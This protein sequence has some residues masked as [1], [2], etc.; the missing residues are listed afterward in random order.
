MQNLEPGRGAQGAVLDMR[1]LREHVA[2]VYAGH[3]TAVLAHLCFAI[4]IAFFVYFHQGRTEP[5]WWLIPI[6]AADLGAFF[7]ARWTPAVPLEDTPRWALR[8]TVASTLVSGATAPAAFFFVASA[9][10]AE[11]TVVTVVIIGS[12]TRAVQARWPLK[13]AIFGYGLPMKCGLIAGLIWNGGAISWFLAAFCTANLILTLRAGV[14]QNRRLTESLMLRFENETLA[15]RLREQVAATERASAEKT[16]FL[17]AA[18]HDL[19]QPMHAIALFGAAMQHGLHQHPERAN[20][21][22]L[23][24]AVDALGASLDTMLDVS[25]LD[26]GVISAMPRPFALDTLLLA[27]H[28]TF[29]AQAEQKGL[30]LRVRASGLWVRSDPQLLLRM[31]SNL[32]DNALK[33]TSQGG[34]TVC[35]LTRGAQVWLEVRDT[36]IGIAPDQLGRIFEEFY[37]VNNPGRD[38]ARGL[39]IGLAIVHRLARL[40][41]HPVQVRSHVGRGTRFRLVLPAAEAQAQQSHEEQ[42]PDAPDGAV[43]HGFAAPRLHGRVL[44]IDDEDEIREGMVQLLR[45]YGLDAVAVPDE[46]AAEQVLADRDALTRPFVLLLCDYRLAEGRDGLQAAQRLRER[47]A[48]QM[49]LLLITGETAPERLVQVRASGTPVLFKPVSAATLLQAIADLTDTARAR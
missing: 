36:G 38:R 48:P 28:Q 19:R 44:L 11:V 8:Y 4:A 31:L 29:S 32:V 43:Q 34:I 18:S 42:L 33:Y 27:V 37:Q 13:G 30:H 46:A 1:V 23:M 45:A 49:P 21:E 7:A 5:L 24:R 35:A 14:Q 12:W 40:L 15:E 26:A 25:R 41:A 6:F 20:A 3:S 39:G 22:R 2:T 10:L 9:D 17:A 47:F 16:R